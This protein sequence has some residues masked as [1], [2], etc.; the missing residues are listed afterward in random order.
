MLQQYS[1]TLDDLASILTAL[2]ALAGL[3]LSIHNLRLSQRDKQIQ[4]KAK[5]SNGFLPRGPDLGELMLILEVSNPGEKLATIT[6]VSLLWRNQTI[7]FIHG[8]QGTTSIPFELPPGKSATFWTPLK[9][10]ASTLK[11]E[12]ARGKAKLMA[13]FHTAVGTDHLSKPF[14]LNIDDWAK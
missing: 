13:Q 2:I 6:S 14:V 3:I 7:A 12:S 8:I 1:I 4:L 9:G 10:L 5:L 11:E